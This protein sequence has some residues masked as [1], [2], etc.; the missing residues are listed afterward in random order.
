LASRA[1]AEVRAKLSIIH[2]IHG[3]APVEEKDARQRLDELQ[4]TVG[5]EAPV[6]MASG[7]VKEA[8]LDAANSAADVLIIGRTPRSG[9]LG[10]MGDL[11]Y[12]LVRD[13]PCPVLSI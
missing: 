4:K 7:P 11:T 5:C 6:R 9:A 12:S 2:V 13:S 1:A 3:G 10:R 8:L